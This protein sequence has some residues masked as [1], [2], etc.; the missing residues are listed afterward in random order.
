VLGIRLEAWVLTSSEGDTLARREGFCALKIPS[1]AMMRDAGIDP[2][3]A[4]GVARTWVLQTVAGLQPDLLLVDTFPGGSSGE[5]LPVLELVR[6]RVLVARAVKSEIAADDAYRTLLPLYQR[7][8]V[9]SEVGDPILLREAHELLA[10]ADARRALGVPDG[11]RAV[12]LSLGG[13]G[14]V[15][16]PDALPRLVDMLLATGDHVVVGAGDPT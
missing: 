4:L 12:Y 5:L 10:R 7:T 13:G 6:E 11:K 9:P 15:T 1:K 14:D 2:G 16:A 8:I 3:R